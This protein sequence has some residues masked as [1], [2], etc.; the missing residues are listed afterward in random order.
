[1]SNKRR[2]YWPLRRIYIW[3]KCRIEGHDWM[4]EGDEMDY[5]IQCWDCGVTKES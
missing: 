1:M 3:F 5:D 2:W 4:E